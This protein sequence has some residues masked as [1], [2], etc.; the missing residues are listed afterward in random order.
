MTANTTLP[1]T[2]LDFDEI[3]AALV[4]AFKANKVFRDFDF[5]GS[6]ISVL[7]DLLAHNSFLNSFYLNMV[8]SEMFLDSANMRDSIVSHSKELSY[9]PQS[10]RSS[11]ADLSFSVSTVGIPGTLTIPKGTSFSGKN[12][13]DTYSFVTS[14]AQVYTTANDYYAIA[15]L[16]VFDGSYLTD[17]YVYD[18][19]NEAQRFVLSNPSI[20]LSSLVVT[21]TENSGNTVTPFRGVSTL[22]GLT[23][24]SNVYFVQGAQNYQYEIVFGDGLFGRI[25][26]DGALVQANYRICYGA[27]ADGVAHFTCDAD[28]GLLNGGIATLSPI[29]VNLRSAG[30]ANAEPDASVRFS[31]PRYFATQQRA[32][33]S[34]DY[35]ALVLD[36][37]GGIISDVAV[38]G[39]QELE[40]KQYGRTVVCLKPASGTA[41]PDYVKNEIITFLDQYLAIPARVI[42]SDP[43]YFYLKVDSIVQYE[44]TSTT[45]EATEIRR[46]VLQSISSYASTNLQKFKGDFRY[47]RFVRQIDDTDDSITSNDTSIKMIKRLQATSMVATSFTVDFNNEANQ[48]LLAKEPVLT[49]S[50]FTWVDENDI[51]YA[52]VWIQDDGLGYLHIYRLVNRQTVLLHSE[53]GA[54]DYEN[55]IVRL[56]DLRMA[57]YGA[58]LCLY[59]TLQ[60]KDVVVRLSQILMVDLSLSGDGVGSDV[61]V[62]VIETID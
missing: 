56:N 41:A 10:K 54:I 17:T 13:N 24:T 61:T 4:T 20:D 34:D 52:R 18:R 22:Y 5:S 11:V 36:N 51:Q 39:G 33:A 58:A 28:L 42:I 46:D 45:Q 43:D 50:Q 14:Q 32:V 21:V 60:N 59:L 37:F 23:S 16:Q 47:S 49:S 44:S 6:N 31:A 26:Q 38:Y 25:P 53:I 8:A 12:S 3:R 57:S 2:G 9:V 48:D 1:L 55:G 29:T 7:M 62:S 27:E 30:G 35:E 19:S 15:N 40:P